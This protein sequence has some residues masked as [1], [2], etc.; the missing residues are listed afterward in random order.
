MNL[1]N[2]LVLVVGIVIGAGGATWWNYDM[3][4]YSYDQGFAVG[5]RDGVHQTL[6]D[7]DI[8]QPGPPGSPG[9]SGQQYELRVVPG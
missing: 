1:R 8:G 6:K 4:K 9:A 7:L 3:A 2:V 5:K